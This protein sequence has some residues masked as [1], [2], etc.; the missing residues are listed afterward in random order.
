MSRV[1]CLA[2]GKSYDG[3]EQETCPYCGAWN[4]PGTRREV[5]VVADEAATVHEDVENIPLEEKRRF[6]LRG[7]NL[8]GL[9]V[10]VIVLVTVWLA[11]Q[12]GLH[13]TEPPVPEAYANIYESLTRLDPTDSLLKREQVYAARLGQPFV[14]GQAPVRV[15]D[16]RVQDGGER[17]TVWIHAVCG[18]ERPEKPSVFFAARKEAWQKGR[19]VKQKETPQGIWYC[20]TLNGAD[21]GDRIVA[22]FSN[23]GPDKTE[24]VQIR[25]D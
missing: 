18:E 21:K 9:L 25:L 14:S 17:T 2:C 3:E 13:T 15:N 11:G 23:D 19:F 4:R 22:V 7:M 8:M 12:E 6:T 24:E 10:I 5:T 1:K 20:F 16:Y